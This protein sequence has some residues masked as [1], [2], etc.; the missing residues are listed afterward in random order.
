MVRRNSNLKNNRISG[1]VSIDSVEIDSY[2]GQKRVVQLIQS[3]DDSK[4]VKILDLIV[5]TIT[6]DLAVAEGQPP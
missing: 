4:R 6:N 1:M 5:D 3:V 2:S